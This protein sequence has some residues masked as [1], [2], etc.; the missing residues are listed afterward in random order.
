[1]AVTTTASL[2]SVTAR[3]ETIA[4]GAAAFENHASVE[5]VG[6]AIGNASSLAIAEPFLLDH[7]TSAKAL[8]AGSTPEWECLRRNVSK[9]KRLLGSFAITNVNDR[10][11][12]FALK[13]TL[14]RFNEMP[15]VITRVTPCEMEEWSHCWYAGAIAEIFLELANVEA[16]NYVSAGSSISASVN[17]NRFSEYIRLWSK[18]EKQFSDLATNIKHQWNLLRNFSP[19]VKTQYRD[20]W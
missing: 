6:E 15:P 16:R 9:V 10:S 18:Y 7:V 12:E 13:V 4:F 19:G 14:M 20:P 2:V 5:A 17:Q 1:M 11:V 8:G 3:H